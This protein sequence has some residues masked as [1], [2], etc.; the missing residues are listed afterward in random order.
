M[1]LFFRKY[2]EG[3][4]LFILHGLYGSSDN[5]VSIA[6]KISS[7]FSV[8]L[9]DARNHGQSPHNDL[10]T[11]KSMACDLLELVRSLG[12]S[13]FFLAGHSM[14]GKCAMYFAINNPEMID[15]LIV[16]DISPFTDENLSGR[17]CE[18]HSNILKTIINTDL[19]T[20]KSR[21]EVESGLASE[22]QSEKVRSLIMKNLLRNED[23]SYSWKINASG[24]LQNLKL[25]LGSIP[26]TTDTYQEITGFPVI[27]LKGENSEY[28]STFDFVKIQRIFPAAEMIIIKD[29]G[30]W[31]H[32]DNPEA[33]SEVLLS[34]LDN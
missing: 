26:D 25:I 1:K 11:Y 28:I 13:R 10:H 20:V 21:S 22:I 8:Y 32:T 14:G 2:G 17:A 34:M 15:G 18:L 31:L 24:L 19:S 33:V 6:K 9:P 4:P 23:G 3:P 7:H 27:F 29:A 30:H 5:W 12:I 16:A